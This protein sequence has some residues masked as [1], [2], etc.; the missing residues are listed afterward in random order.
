MQYLQTEQLYIDRYD[1]HT[2]ET[3]LQYYWNLRKGM[4]VK[5]NELKDISDE[6]F[7]KDLHKALSYTVN[8]IKIE[9]FRHKTERITEWMDKDRKTQE[10]YDTA[11][12]PEGIRCKECYSD[13]KLNSK[14]LF[15]AYEKDAHVI[16]MFECVKCH[17]R[18][19]L[20]TDGREWHYNPPRCPKCTASLESTM[21]YKK[22]VLMTTYTCPSCAYTRTDVDDFAKFHKEQDAQKQKDEKLLAEYRSEFCYTEE[23][24]RQA[25]ESA[26]GIARVMKEWKEREKKE[27]DPLFQQAMKLK[28]ISIVDMEKLIVDAITS[29]KYI[30][31]T[32]GQPVMGR[33]V[34]VPF[35]AQDTDGNRSEYDSKNHLKKLITKVLEGTNWRLMSDGISGRLGVLSG[36]LKGMEQED[37]LIESVK[38]NNK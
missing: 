2:I 33:F 18:Q 10:V 5:R 25:V 12:P 23:V 9:R 14:D 17:K 29:Q 16:F 4:E 27:A 21:K 32:L 37:D 30:R 34:E 8:A 36:R 22:E 6:D 26:D 1:L 3:C 35:T 11:R 7:N 13:T 38:E 28:K 24:G 19:A 20:Y 15:N 31:F